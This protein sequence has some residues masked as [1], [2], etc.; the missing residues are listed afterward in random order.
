[1][2]VLR[3]AVARASRPWAPARGRVRLTVKPFLP[4]V[5]VR[6]G[7]RLPHWTQEGATYAVTFHLADSLPKAVGDSIRFERKD[8]VETAARM[9]RPLTRH[10]L[11]RLQE[12]FSER[13]QSLLDEGRGKAWMREDRIA[14]IVAEAVGFFDGERY[15]LLAWCVMPNHVH[16]VLQPLPGHDLPA[17]LHAWK[18]FTAKQINTAVASKGQVW[19][20][21]YYDHLIRDERDLEN[22]VN[23]VLS[24][25]RRARLDDWKWVGAAGDLGFQV[26]AR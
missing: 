10:E 19:E 7:A 25:P 17:I 21:E 1:M 6:H 24:N 12:L 5:T 26:S 22:Q 4:N 16:A 8:I 18:S 14:R 9:K 23:Y 13:L 15:R 20:T 3:N 2:A 11:A